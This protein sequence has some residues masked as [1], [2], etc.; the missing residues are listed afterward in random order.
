MIRKDNFY[1]NIRTKYLQNK[2]KNTVCC[3]FTDDKLYAK[4]K[5]FRNKIRKRKSRRVMRPTDFAKL[6]LKYCLINGYKK[7]ERC[8][9]RYTNRRKLF[10]VYGEAVNLH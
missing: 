10:L 6:I 9:A 7:S 3:I 5:F 2:N 1:K 4:N 8:K